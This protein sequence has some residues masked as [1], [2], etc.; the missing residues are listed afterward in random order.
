MDDGL[1]ASDSDRTPATRH[2][3]SLERNYRRLLAFYPA[4]Y[5]RVHEEEMLTVLMTVAPN[6]KC[7]PGL[8]ETADLIL[9]ALRVWCQ[10]SCG[11]MA[12]KRGALALI[13]AVA[14]LGLIAGAAA[15]KANP[16]LP[17][18]S[19]TVSIQPYIPG[20]S[21]TGPAYTNNP[22]MLER[23][24]LSIRPAISLQALQS[25]VQITRTSGRIVVISAQQV[26]TPAEALRAAVAVA[27]S[28]IAYVSGK[29]APGGHGT[30]H[31]TLLF[32]SSVSPRTSMFTD[33]LDFGALGALCGAGIGAIGAAALRRPSR[34]FRM[35]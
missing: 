32:V 29:D 18:V 6:G 20:E 25:Q 4:G 34:R 17:G 12:G 24:A 10:P 7:R 23:A 28:Y 22:V 9:G 30:M 5:R 31:P 8:A 3:R 26:T 35:T 13:G 11:G 21:Y 1:R 14:L 19:A 15:A 27:Q 16:P 2:D 33:P